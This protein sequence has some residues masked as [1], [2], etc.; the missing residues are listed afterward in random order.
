MGGLGSDMVRA[1]ARYMVCE[2][3]R[4]EFVPYATMI[5]QSASWLEDELLP[6]CSP[7]PPPLCFA[8]TRIEQLAERS[9]SAL[10][11]I[12]RLR[13]T[14]RAWRSAVDYGLMTRVCLHARWLRKAG[15]RVGQQLS[16][17]RHV[18]ASGARD[19]GEVARHVP[20]V[21]RWLP[22]LETLTLHCMK[23]WSLPSWLREVPLAELTMLLD[24]DWAGSRELYDWLM[25]PASAEA[26][27]PTLLELDLRSFGDISFVFGELPVCL[28]SLHK[29]RDLWLGQACDAIQEVPSWFKSLASLSRLA[30]GTSII[31]FADA[32]REMRLTALSV[33][34]TDYRLNADDTKRLQAVLDRLFVATALGASLRELNLCWWADALPAFPPSLRHCP[35]LTALNVG[36]SS[37]QHAPGWLADLP[38]ALLDVAGA[39][40]TTVPLVFRSMASL[41]VVVVD[42]NIPEHDLDDFRRARPDVDLR[43]FSM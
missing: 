23:I 37:I 36:N 20:D 30:V 6:S 35:R 15:P 24:S 1:V 27:P 21:V 19:T 2:S 39:K 32:I 33:D 40:F 31:A 16:R 3:S 34:L 9:R 22:R 41:R 25:S 12:E 42:D 17:C 4:D 7:A 5:H 13:A 28:R 38:I 14:C 10:R 18:L 29:L 26:V 8:G 11:A 43:V